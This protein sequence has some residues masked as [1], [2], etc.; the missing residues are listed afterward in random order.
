M[1]QDAEMT[2]GTACGERQVPGPRGSSFT[3]S[4]SFLA[5]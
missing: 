3:A 2:A 5:S 1:A 4:L